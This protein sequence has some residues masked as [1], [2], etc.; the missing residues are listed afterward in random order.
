MFGRTGQGWIQAVGDRQSSAVMLQ[1]EGLS[2]SEQRGV[3]V[4]VLQLWK[5]S[6]IASGVLRGSSRSRGGTICQGQI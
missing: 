1:K 3:A 2:R 5:S 6:Q 4:D